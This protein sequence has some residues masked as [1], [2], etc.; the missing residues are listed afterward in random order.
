MLSTKQSSGS[1]LHDVSIQLELYR[2]L[3]HR[4]RKLYGKDEVVELVSAGL[5]NS[6]SISP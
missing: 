5:L 3:G 6:K 4:N 2:V 1:G